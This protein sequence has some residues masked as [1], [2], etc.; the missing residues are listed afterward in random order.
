MGGTT[1]SSSALIV[2]T[3]ATAP[4][5]PR[6]WPI[7]D[8]VAVTL[9]LRGVVAHERVDAH[10]LGRVALAGAGGVGAD[11]VDVAGL[12]AGLVQGATRGPDGAR[13]RRA[14]AW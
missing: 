4:A 1:P 2:A 11:E 8:L 12:Q 13:C 5:A 3:A 10:E 9:T 14:R 6:V 7:D